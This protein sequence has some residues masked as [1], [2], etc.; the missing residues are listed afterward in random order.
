MTIKELLKQSGITHSQKDEGRLG[1]RIRQKAW[2]EKIR[3]TKKEEIIQVNDY[4]PEFEDQMQEM[5]IQ[6]FKNK[7]VK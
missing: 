4:P 7:T 5:A 2:E 1:L 6:Y 3:W